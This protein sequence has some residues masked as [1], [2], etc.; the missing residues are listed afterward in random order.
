M[1][2]R[3]HSDSD[4]RSRILEAAGE[5][6][7]ERGFRCATVRR[8]CEKA[9]VN[10]SAI[11]YH[12]GGKEALYFEVLNFWHEFAIKKYPPLF[13][14]GENAPP[15]EQLRAFIRSFLFR[16]LDK[17][18]P[19][20]FGKLMARETAEPTRAF[21][22][23]VKEVMGERHK[24]L[25]SIIQKIVG[26]PGSERRVLLCCMSIIGQCVYYYNTHYTEQLL[27]QDMSSPEEIE[28][29][30]DHI[31]GFS[32]RGLEYCCGAERITTRQ[33]ALMR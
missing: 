19:A 31:M 9:G 28:R 4:T 21:D 1:K 15:E 27:G 25:A 2:S 17:G 16:L 14:A 24:L 22:H 13:G 29:I 8:I 18:K 6:F 32:L 30:A 5:I 7:A 26:A 20:W 33:M 11:K 3:V 23:M 12:F 10:L